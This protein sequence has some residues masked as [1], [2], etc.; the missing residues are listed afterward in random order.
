MLDVLLK[1]YFDFIKTVSLVMDSSAN[2]SK[3]H[4][5]TRVCTLDKNKATNIYPDS[6][7]TFRVAHNFRMLW[8]QH[9]FLTYSEIT[10]K[11]GPSPQELLDAII[12]C[13]F[14]Y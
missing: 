13:Y 9:G 10:I 1:Y 5:L 3:S 8:K 12:I 11:N 14:S 6:R 7:Q 4:T 2:Q